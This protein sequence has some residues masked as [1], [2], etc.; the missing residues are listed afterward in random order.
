MA[1]WARTTR[2][3]AAALRE[4]IGYA[5][6]YRRLVYAEEAADAWLVRVVRGEPV[7]GSGAPSPYVLRRWRAA[8]P[9]FAG[10]YA[11][12]KLSG[13]RRRMAAR[14]KLTPKLTARIVERIRLGDSLRSLSKR[15]G[16]PHRVTLYGW[17]KSRPG[18]AA[19]VAKACDE[20][21]FILNE[22]KLMRLDGASE[23]KVRAT[24]AQIGAVTRRAR[25]RRPGR[26]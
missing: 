23:T 17:L 11:A 6:R 9:D 20:R 5:R 19:A 1:I 14:R 22:Q 3:I 8:D 4:A 25:R 18:F 21:D 13:H 12:A 26:G 10:A 24:M 16:M 15:R 7:G 2:A